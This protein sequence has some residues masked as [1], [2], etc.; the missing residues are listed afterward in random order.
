MSGEIPVDPM[1][2]VDEE[3]KEPLEV[4]VPEDLGKIKI[5]PEGELSEEEQQLKDK[6]EACVERLVSGAPD[7]KSTLETLRMEIQTSTSSLTAVPKPLKHL[8][9]HAK[10]LN[11]CFQKTFFGKG[12][13][14][15]QRTFADV[16]AVLAMASVEETRDCLRY[17]LLGNKADLAS[18][19]HEFVRALAGDVSGESQDLAETL[20]ATTEEDGM[21]EIDQAQVAEPVVFPPKATME[22]LD[23]MINIIFP[24]QVD[25]NLESEA[26]DMLFD[27]DRLPRIVEKVHKANF[28]RVALYLVR[29]AD[30]TTDAEETETVLRTAFEVYMKENEFFDALR[31]ALRFG[32]KEWVHQVFDTAREVA[33]RPNA[34]KRMKLV[35]KQCAALMGAHRAFWYQND[36][37]ADLE[38]IVS[39]VRASDMY[40]RLAR[41]LNVEEAKTPED[42]YKSHLS[43]TGAVRREAAQVESARQNLASTF[44]NGFVNCGFIKDSLVAV[45]GNPF[46]YKNKDHGMISATASL[47][48]I[49]LWDVDEGMSQIDKFLYSTNVHVKAGALLALGIVG[50]GVRDDCEPALGMLPGHLDSKCSPDERN[51][52]SLGLGLAYAGNPKPDIFDALSPVIQ[53]TTQYETSCIA[54]LSLGFSFCG[55]GDSD[56]S[57]TLAEHLMGIADADLDKSCT[58]FLVLGLALVFLGKQDGADAIQEILSTIAHPI[59]TFAKTLVAA[60]AYAG[61]GNVLQVQNFLLACAGGGKA[62]DD[63]AA[64]TSV[65]AAPAAALGGANSQVDAPDAAQQDRNEVA[66]QNIHQSAAVIGIALVT[67][68]ESIGRGM[69]DRTFQHLLQY[70]DVAV[71]RSVPLALALAYTSNPDFNV[72]DILSRLTHDADVETACCAILALGICGSGTNNSRI[73]GLLRLLATFYA[74]DPSPLFVVRIAQGLLHAGKGL[75]TLAP[76]HTD[77]SLMLQPSICG[78][79]TVLIA[80]LDMKSSFLG[81]LHYLLF[82]LAPAIRPRMV[83]CVDENLNPVN[84][85][86]VRIGVSVDT[87]GLAG[88][89]KTITGFQTHNSPALMSVGERSE[90]A[91]PEKWICAARVLESIVFVEKVSEVDDGEIKKD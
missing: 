18:W 43:E 36:A 59:H 76:Y 15:L 44:V 14:E 79:L 7:A 53:D 33:S 87:V 4:P 30:Y 70:G 41:E 42:V 49:L 55:T 6:L 26:I 63:A 74:K 28:D 66:R 86:Q 46:I 5:L 51:C 88:K 29:L 27:C 24:F 38:R 52:A 34:T 13:A 23:E 11:G 22:E 60:C 77:R 12:D 20:P 56:A 25:R 65:A 9:T 50:S 8:R 68:G 32:S 83:Y 39:N 37:D 58:R 54:A 91:E 61:S 48:L 35:R 21:V 78:L 84:G 19:G 82:A 69:A 10:A 75:V 3:R 2:K 72:V 16:L 31:V 89:P 62:K 64:A 71:R 67:M 80:S 85:V 1:Q 73:A 45:E 90:F 17:K 57:L 81:R 47:G 40:R